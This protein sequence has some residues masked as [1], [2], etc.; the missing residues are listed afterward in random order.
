M[1][2]KNVG[3]SVINVKSHSFHS[4]NN[5]HLY[6]TIHKYKRGKPRQTVG[7]LT[8]NAQIPQSA[9]RIKLNR[10]IRNNSIK[11]YYF[12]LKITSF[13]WIFACFSDLEIKKNINKYLKLI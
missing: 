5:F 8:R 10:L 4:E 7:I 12:L 1:Y 3:K 13:S 9:I 2:H 6:F 11:F